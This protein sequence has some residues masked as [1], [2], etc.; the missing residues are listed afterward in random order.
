MDTMP[1]QLVEE[2][3]NLELYVA[4]L[5]MV[6]YRAFPED[7]DLWWTL[8]NEEKNHAA[9]IKSARNIFLNNDNFPKELLAS[10]L[11]TLKNF[12]KKLLAWI[13]EFEQTPP[14]REKAL[15]LAVE[16]EQSEGEAAYQMAMER[17]PESKEMKIL[18]QLNGMDKDHADRIRAYMRDADIPI[19]T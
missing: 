3:I 8:L 1:K 17:P 10:D 15:N 4:D 11:E 7:A 6:F 13:S 18:Q 16:I 19:H 2:A 14:T 9:L 12:N 5:Y